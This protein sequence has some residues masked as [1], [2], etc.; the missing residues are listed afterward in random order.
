[1]L[2][3]LLLL[4]LHQLLLLLRVVVVRRRDRGDGVAARAHVQG[5][6]LQQRLGKLGLVHL[7][8]VVEWRLVVELRLLLL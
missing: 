4:L 1:M 3:L 6:R 2:L 8:L 7:L 5:L